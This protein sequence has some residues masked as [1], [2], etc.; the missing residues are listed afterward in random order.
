MLHIDAP[1]EVVFKRAKEKALETG[2]EVPEDELETALKNAS[3][4]AEL[5]KPKVDYFCRL[6]NDPEANDLHLRTEGE[7]WGSFKSNWLQLCKWVPGMNKSS[8][9][10][11]DD[12]SNLI[13]SVVANEIS[14]HKSSEE[15]HRS[16]D[17]KFYGKFASIRENLDY[18]YHSNYTKE[19]QH[20]QDYIIEDMLES[21]SITDVNGDICTTPEKPWIVFTAGAMGAGK[22]YTIATLVKKKHFPLL[23]FVSVDPDEI[24]RH[25]PEFMLYSTLVPENAGNLTNKECGYISE[26]LTTAGLQ[27]G[28]NVIVDGSLRDY[29]WYQIYFRKLKND[30][31]DLKIA[32]L[33]VVAPREAVFERAEARAKQT[34]RQVPRKLLEDAMEQVPRSVKILSPL[35]DYFAELN[36]APGKSD[37]ELLTEGECWDTFRSQWL[38][39]CKFVPGGQRSNP[40]GRRRARLSDFTKKPEN[41]IK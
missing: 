17:M 16:D 11:V 14:V 15:N 38:Q 28:K 6:Y 5:L 23:A 39:L 36:N 27:A 41:I 21:A 33:H 31:P 30:Y 4:S 8:T 7:T 32:I 29:Q 34:G 35:S 2:F 1:R 9:E 13:S 12:S 37:I 18:S 40:F 24:R 3:N 25:L 20:I 10:V 22:G 19:R 26:I